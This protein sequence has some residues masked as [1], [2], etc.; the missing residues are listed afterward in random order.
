MLPELF[1]GEQLLGCH[2]GEVYAHGSPAWVTDLYLDRRGVGFVVVLLLVGVVVL[3][4]E[5]NE[6]HLGQGGPSLAAFTHLPG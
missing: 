2:A 3:P 1:H 4:H 5:E 6:L